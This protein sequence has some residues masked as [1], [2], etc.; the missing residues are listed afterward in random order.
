MCSSLMKKSLFFPN[1]K[2]NISE[3]DTKQSSELPDEICRYIFNYLGSLE[4]VVS[5]SKVNKQWYK[6]TI[7]AP[8]WKS[9][10]AAKFPLVEP[11]YPMQ[12]ASWRGRFLQERKHATLNAFQLVIEKI[13]QS[14]PAYSDEDN[15][16]TVRV[17]K[18]PYRCL[19]R[20]ISDYIAMAIITPCAL[21]FL[22][23]SGGLFSLFTIAALMNLNII[24]S[25]YKSTAYSHLGVE[26]SPLGGEDRFNICLPRY[27]IPLTLG[28][29]SLL[30]SFIVIRYKIQ[31]DIREYHRED[32]SQERS[33]SEIGGYVKRNIRNRCEIL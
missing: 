15:I 7:F 5:C 28:L 14:I 19:H 6:N 18:K 23:V 27:A 29:T 26:K 25:D 30:L 17:K 32:H 2:L 11:G 1:S 12:E 4:D 24:C 8:H 22:L 13:D 31:E 20:C 16:N 3:S 33:W 9:A 21:P 10:F